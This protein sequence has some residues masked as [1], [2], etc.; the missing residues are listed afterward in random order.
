M[1][2]RD[3]SLRATVRAAVLARPPIDDRERESLR[4]FVRHLDLLA[5]PFSE[6][7]APVHVTGSAIL[8]GR[9]G[10]V[11]HRHK[12][13]GIWLQPG[14]HIDDGEAPWDGAAREAFEETGLVASH[15]QAGPELIHV[16]VHPGPRGHTHLDLR[17][18][19]F[20]DDVDPAPPRG[21][22]Q[23]VRWFSWDEADAVADP[24]LSGA[25]RS[26]RDRFEHCW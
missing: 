2:R 14:G 8:V 22:S 23:A 16:D 17:Y 13:L 3:Q 19:L 4:E 20:A 5:E 1:Q 10:V 9:R 6:D 7:A 25:L 24:G 15:P 21:E 18:L 11:L 12:R 26:I